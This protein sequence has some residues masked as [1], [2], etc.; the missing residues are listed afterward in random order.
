MSAITTFDLAELTRDLCALPS[1]TGQEEAIADHL[2]AWLAREAPAA[3]VDRLG[4]SVVARV[5]GAPGEPW[6]ML[7]GHIDT[8]PAAPDQEVTI[9]DG[10]VYGCGA[11]DMKGA[12]AVMLDLVARA[13]NSA[14]RP[15][16]PGALFVFYD[17]EE[18]PISESTMPAL[19]DSGLLPESID[20]ALC[21]EPTD[22]R[23]EAGCVGGLHA[24]VTVHG[25][26]AHSARPWQGTNA[27]IRAIPL[28]ERLA[29][30]E[31]RPVEV[32]GL[33]FREVVSPTTARTT[34]GRNVV[35]DRFELNLNMRFAPD[36]EASE[37]IRELEDFVGAEG[38]VEIIDIA[39]PG[40]VVTEVPRLVA[41]ARHFGLTFEA[42]QAWTDV[43]QL[44]SR[45]IPAANFGPGL[46]AQ[47]HQAGEHVPVANLARAWEM[48][49]RLLGLDD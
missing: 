46:T 17:R 24:R 29:R 35:P 47:A 36:R 41:W 40:K 3:R 31:P 11:S 18:G 20:L 6:V 1:E 12:V 16:R 9:R 44:S 2:V 30:W 25:K 42:K 34:N 21:L 28:L 45:G 27:I 19:L 8:V 38:T 5:S 10:Q 14:V 26:R 15:G 23:I 7:V 22:L 33:V 4:H 49:A 48:L 32:G 13:A 37:A 39:P 43:A